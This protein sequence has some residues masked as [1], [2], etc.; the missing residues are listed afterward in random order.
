MPDL[1]GLP[2][3]ALTGLLARDDIIVEIE[4]DGWVRE[5]SP[6]PG[7]PIAAGATIRLRLE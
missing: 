7:E 6:A 2:K 5:Q 4:G 3:R 1:R